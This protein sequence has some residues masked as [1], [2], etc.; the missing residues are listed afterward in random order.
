MEVG[1]ELGKSE[2]REK[3][4]EDGESG[5]HFWKGKKEEENEKS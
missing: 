2:R 1:R 3:K 5:E 4:E